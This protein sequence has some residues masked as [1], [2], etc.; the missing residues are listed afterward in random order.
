MCRWFSTWGR[1]NH[2]KMD[3]ERLE[4]EMQKA[5]GHMEF[6]CRLYRIQ[7]A[8]GGY[9]L[10]EHPAGATSWDLPCVQD[11]LR[12]TGV[13]TVMANMC[14]FGMVARDDDGVVRPVA[15]LTTFM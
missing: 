1:I 10:H 11:I 14:C 8:M 6:V 12:R 7:L 2:P 13:S 15:K 5:I 9:I 4:Q 3:Q